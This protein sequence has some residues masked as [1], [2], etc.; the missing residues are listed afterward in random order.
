M[1]YSLS[2]KSLLNLDTQTKELLAN[3]VPFVLFCGISCSVFIVITINRISAGVIACVL[4]ISSAV[5]AQEKTATASITGKVTVKN[6]GVAGV[7][8]FAHQQNI[9]G[10]SSYRGATDQTGIYRIANLPA[11]T[12]VISPV[13]PSLALEDDLRNNS[14]VV[15]EGE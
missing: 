15:S 12:Y 4:L 5:A 6:K 10:R 14:V 11:G 2:K 9:S 7:A 13:A 1:T 8:V 3:S